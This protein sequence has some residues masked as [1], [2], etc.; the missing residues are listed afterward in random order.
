MPRLDHRG[1]T[2]LELIVVIGVL[3]I[4]LAASHGG[5]QRLIQ[6]ERLTEAT[7]QVV[8]HLRLSRRK[9]VS[10]GNDYIVTFRV[11]T[12]DYQIWDDKGSD[13][14][15]GP[16]DVRRTFPMPTGI[17]VQ[18]PIFSGGN[19]VTF[20]P[21]GTF[22]AAGSVQVTNGESFRQVNVLASTREIT[23]TGP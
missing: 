6:S 10:E 7:N 16:N 2:A 14:I 18:N 9:A 17:L 22:D 3:G 8:T 13:S 1:L 15:L 12:N 19:R 11:S 21:D 20:R 5:F 23:V 4:V